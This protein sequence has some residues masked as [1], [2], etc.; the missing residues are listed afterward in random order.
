MKLSQFESYF[1]PTILQRGKNYFD[2]HYVGKFIQENDHSWSVNVKGSYQSHY[3]VK[4][5][6]NVTLNSDIDIQSM[7]CNCDYDD[8]CKHMVAA[9]YQL[10]TLSPDKF[11]LK[12]ITI[13][14]TSEPLVQQLQQFNAEQLR[15]FILTL[16]N[17]QPE[18]AQDWIFW[19]SQL[20]NQPNTFF[21]SAENSP[22]SNDSVIS[23]QEILKT[24]YQRI[25]SILD[26][27]DFDEDS[28]YEYYYEYDWNE[29]TQPF[30]QLLEKFVYAPKFQLEACIYWVNQIIDSVGEVVDESDIA[31]LLYPA[32]QLFG[33]LLFNHNDYGYM[34][35]EQ[36]FTHYQLP[37]H[38]Q[39]TAHTFTNLETFFED[40]AQH[41]TDNFL[42]LQRLWFDFL[43]VQ[44]KYDTAL[45]WL[46]K[47]INRQTKR[48]G[49]EYSVPRLVALKLGLLKY[50][51]KKQEYYYT[52]NNFKGF[53]DIRLLFVKECL[54]HG[55]VTQAITLINEGIALAK[56]QNYPGIIHYWEEQLLAIAQQYPT[57]IDTTA[58]YRKHHFESAFRYGN[59]DK[60]S[61]LA[62]KATFSL[63]EWELAKKQAQA[64]L[65]RDLPAT[66]DLWRRGDASITQLAAF[67]AIENEQTALIALTKKYPIDKLLF[68]Y[69]DILMDA[70]KDWLIKTFIGQLKNRIEKVASRSEYAE[71]AR[72]IQTIIALLPDDKMPFKQLVEAWQLRFS[73]K[74]KKPALLDELSKI[75]W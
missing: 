53:K 16:V 12:T 9:L 1:S 20:S 10:R 36:H 37:E 61:F 14:D 35:L 44:H 32:L 52:L 49:A 54:E 40:W 64:K 23:D 29:K 70:D 48:N 74:P 63:D 65:I 51:N 46:E 60:H 58:I 27:D 15:E 18:I 68:D 66:D 21:C 2:N 75:N 42:M 17:Q 11:N 22:D 4:L 39:I 41:A 19:V 50:L 71:L 57:D 28:Y 43:I 7:R 31:E 73:S 30:T 38:H 69:H 33:K 8:D 26:L 24:I 13:H 56:Q 25:D 67:Y 34:G 3:K 47:G 55:Q 72:Y 62:W 5:S 59:F 6:I 45:T